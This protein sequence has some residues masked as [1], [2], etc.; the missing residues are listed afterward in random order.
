MSAPAKSHGLIGQ[1]THYA[2]EVQLQC[3]QCGALLG[4]LRE[5]G[6]P[7]EF[8]CSCANCSFQMLN[9]DG[10]WKAL[11]S[12]R[13]AHFAQFMREYPVVREAEGRVSVNPEYYLAL[14]YQDLSGQN[15]EQWAIRG[16]TYDFVERKILPKIESRTGRELKILDLGAGNGWMSYR[17]ALRSHW[18]VAIDLLASEM[19]GLAAAVHY[20]K[21]L[22]GLFPRFQAD[23]SRLPFADSQFDLA[24]FNASFHYAEDYAE[25]LG[26]A[27]RCLHPG[28]TVIIADTAWYKRD[29]SGRR[30]LAERRR[31]FT[32]RF[33]FPSNGLASM[34]YL[35]D[36][37]LAA[38][39]RRFDL[40]WKTYSP[41]YG[42]RWLMRPV[43]AKLKGKREPSRFRIY[44]AEVE[45]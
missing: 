24:I 37:R 43:L 5:D 19:D 13:A 23:L 1:G 21:R 7:P 45:K 30:M 27:I 33:G 16:R 31:A 14:P 18:P 25:T 15:R 4:T 32:E 39:A 8:S 26:E 2:L 3:P 6:F 29:E 41:F 42:V 11:T 38:L 35:T 10:V 22:P 40:G 44:V 34:E 20:R 28:G 9:E 17:L 12:K 36:E